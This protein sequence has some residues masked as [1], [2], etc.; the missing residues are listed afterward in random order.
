MQFTLVKEVP[1]NLAKDEGVVCLPDFVAQIKR[2]KKMFGGK[3]QT[4]VPILRN[5]IFAIIEDYQFNVNELSAYTGLKLNVYGGIE[6]NSE[7]ELGK[8]VFDIIAKHKPDVIQK[9]IQR[10]IA[11]L[12]PGTNLMYFVAPDFTWTRGFADIG[13]HSK[14]KESTKK[15]KEKEQTE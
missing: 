8:V 12:K 14:P 13:I 6:F 9:I 1:T 4:S 3:N 10:D 7:A 5:I 15:I 11:K 2:V